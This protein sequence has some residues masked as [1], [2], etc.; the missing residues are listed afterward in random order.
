V[1]GFKA[2]YCTIQHLRTMVSQ[3]ETFQE[4]TG[5]ANAEEALTR[6]TMLAAEDEESEEAGEDYVSVSQFPRAILWPLGPRYIR[7][8]NNTFSSVSP[9]I[10]TMEM[11]IPDSV[12]DTVSDGFDYFSPLMDEFIDEVLK[13]S[14]TRN[15]GMLNIAEA[16]VVSPPMPI[17]KKKS[18]GVRIWDC[19]VEVIAKG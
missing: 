2:L 18:Q 8:T 5:S 15:P 16:S 10:I 7:G 12:P 1:A 14:V 19:D 11:V 4:I 13:M 3:S 9:I 6:I 17:E